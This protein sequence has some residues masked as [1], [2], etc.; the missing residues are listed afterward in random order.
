MK[1]G[2]LVSVTRSYLPDNEDLLGVLLSH[3]IEDPTGDS[4]YKFR[5]IGRIKLLLSSGDFCDINLYEEDRVRVV[6]SCS[7]W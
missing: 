5:K 1:R 2:D 3:S 6:Q 4:P 7:S